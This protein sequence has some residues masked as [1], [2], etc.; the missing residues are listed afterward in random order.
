MKALLESTSVRLLDFLDYSLRFPSGRGEFWFQSGIHAAVPTGDGIFACIVVASLRS[1]LS[2]A[3]GKGFG[4]TL[5]PQK[6][7]CWI[8]AP[9][10]VLRRAFAPA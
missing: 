3:G 8:F 5:A 7:F 10:Q 9:W 6:A 2:L 4:E 1:Q